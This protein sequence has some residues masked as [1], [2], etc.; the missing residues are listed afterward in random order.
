MSRRNITSCMK[1]EDQCGPRNPMRTTFA[2]DDDVLEAARELASHR[3]KSIGEVIS[4][5]ARQT[6]RLNGFLRETRNG[7]PL[8]PRRAGAPAVTLE[9]IKL[10]DDELI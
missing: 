3:C 7:V 9:H 1:P 4:S 10:F 2:I 8:L 5:L 6:L